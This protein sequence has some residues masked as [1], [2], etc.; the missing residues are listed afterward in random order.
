MQFKS[1]KKGNFSK[2][3]Q[4]T[5]YIMIAIVIVGVLIFLFYPRIK[6]L[7][8]PAAPPVYLQDCLKEEV[9]ETIKMVSSRGG[10]V[11]PV[12][13]VMFNNEKVE[14]LCYTNQYYQTCKM[15]QPLLIQHIEREILENIKPKA[16]V[17]IDNLKEELRKRGYSVSETREEISVEIMPENIRVAV[18]GISF[19]SE[20]RGERYEKFEINLKSRLYDLIMLTTSIL[21]WE[22]RYGDSDITSY[23]LY[24]PNVKVEKYKQGDGS[25]IYILTDKITEDSLTFATRSLS[26]P[27]GY[28]IGQTYKPVIV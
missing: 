12:N 13:A 28:G 23:M 25:K 22:T 7:I 14:Y 15:Q 1:E 24:Y 6:T 19:V 11:E 4:V 26:W 3:G 10:S 18:S 2:K 5:I 9:E 21:N 16:K 8:K 27:A 17:C 20:E